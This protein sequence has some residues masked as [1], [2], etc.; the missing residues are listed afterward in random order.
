MKEALSHQQKNLSWK[1]DTTITTA[2]GALLQGE[3]I[4]ASTDTVP[5]LL[6]SITS[7]GFQKLR[8]LKGDRGDKPFLILIAAREL[9]T[10]IDPTTLNC[11]IIAL[12]KHCW[13]GPLTIVFK[14]HPNLT[15]FLV[16]TTGTIALRCPAHQGLQKLLT[17]I[18]GIF[19]PSANR[20]NCPPPDCLADVDRA[21]I[22]AVAYVIT[23]ENENSNPVASTI[24]DVTDVK[25]DSAS[26]VKKIRVLR[27]GAYQKKVIERTYESAY[28][29]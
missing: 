8:W 2:K 26:E 16:S 7:V 5:G 28:S 27:G 9:F 3:I 23:D 20:S 13:P 21:L 1:N 24:I 12:T 17:T 10:F 6:G 25:N 11:G 14:A 4:I 19:A 18:P 29:K 15:P 22:D